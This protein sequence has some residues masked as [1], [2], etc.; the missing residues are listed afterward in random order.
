MILFIYFHDQHEIN[1]I[2]STFSSQNNNPTRKKHDEVLIT[3][4]SLIFLFFLI[5][6]IL[7]LLHFGIETRQWS[8]CK[9]HGEVPNSRYAH[10]FSAIDSKTIC[11]FGGS[12]GRTYHNTFYLLDVGMSL[13]YFFDLSVELFGCRKKR[14]VDVE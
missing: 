1:F 2:S 7:I 11:L 8:L 4:K 12:A 3:F 13:F 6:T 14:D 5:V 9:T 10:S